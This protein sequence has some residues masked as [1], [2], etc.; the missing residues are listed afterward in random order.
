MRKY[1]F[2]CFE[3]HY[4]H[5]RFF[6]ILFFLICTSSIVNSTYAQNTDLVL[7]KNTLSLGLEYPFRPE[8]GV[9]GLIG[10]TAMYQRNVTPIFSYGV[11]FYIDDYIYEGEHLAMAPLFVLANFNFSKKET[12]FY[13]GLKVGYGYWLDVQSGFAD[14]PRTY[15]I[16]LEIGKKF[17]LQSFSKKLFSLYIRANDWNF[18]MHTNI[19]AGVAIHL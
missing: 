19:S 2:I 4:L 15:Y 6:V 5:K 11:G 10:V 1:S 12:P 3:R 17:R 18:F 14:S 8:E 9:T 13:M 7:K 16:G